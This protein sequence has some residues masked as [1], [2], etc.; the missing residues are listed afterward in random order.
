[1]L[2]SCDTGE[3]ATCIMGE[4]AEA[5]QANCICEGDDAVCVIGEVHTRVRWE[6]SVM[7]HAERIQIIAGKALLQK[8][9]DLAVC[10]S[11]KW[12]SVNE[13]DRL[14]ATCFCKVVLIEAVRHDC[15]SMLFHIHYVC[16]INLTYIVYVN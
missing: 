5:V 11:M 14:A 12:P 15:S 4:N 7:A 2:R 3:C 6:V 9:D 16:V 8:W 10:C 13:N 1:M